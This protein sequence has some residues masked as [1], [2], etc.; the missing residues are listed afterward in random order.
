MIYDSGNNKVIFGGDLEILRSAADT[1]AL[2]AGDVWADNSINWS[3]V[4]KTGSSLADLATRAYSDLTGR[5]ADDDFNTLTAET[6]VEDTDIVLIYDS[7]ASAYRKM[8]RANFV[9]GVASVAAGDT[10]QIQFNTADA[11]NADSN[12]FWDNTNKWLGIGTSTPEYALEVSG[13]TA[14]FGLSC[15]NT[16]ATQ[17]TFYLRKARGTEAS[18]AAVQDADYLGG[19]SARVYT[20]AGSWQT[21]GNFYFIAEGTPATTN[22]PTSFYLALND[23]TARTTRLY[24]SPGGKFAT[25]GETAP[26][27]T[28]G[29]LCLNQGANDLNILTFKSSDISQPQ[30]S[31]AETDTYFKAAKLQATGGGVNLSGYTDTDS[32]FKCGMYLGGFVASAN[33]G[34]TEFG[35][36]TVD[37]YKTDGGAGSI[38]LAGTENSFAVRNGATGVVVVVKGT[39]DILSQA[40]L[41]IASYGQTAAAGAIQW[42][43]TNFQGYNGSSWVNLDTQSTDVA[44]GDTGQ[45]QFNTADAFN[46]DSNLFWDNTNKRLAVGNATPVGVIH[47]YSSSLTAAESQVYVERDVADAGAAQLVFYRARGSHAALQASDWIGGVTYQGRNATQ[48]TNSAAIFSSVDG[49]PSA[50]VVPGTLDFWTREISGT[51][52]S[53]FLISS[54]GRLS[55]GGETAPDVD[56]GGLCLNH[57]AND[58]KVLS[59]KNGDVAHPFTSYAEADTYFTAVKA[60]NTGGGVSMDAYT[61]A[62]GGAAFNVGGYSATPNTGATGIGVVNVNFRKTDGSTGIA[63]I[64]DTDVGV[65]FRNHSTVKAVIFGSGD[66]VTQAGLKIASYGQTAAAGAIQW[67]GTNFQ[68]YNGTAWVNLDESGASL[69]AGSDTQI[70]FNNAG[71]FG[72][73]SNLTWS[74][75]ALGVGGDVKVG[76]TN[77]YYLG[78][79]STDGSWRFGLDTGDMVLEKRVSGVWEVEHKFKG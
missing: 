39:G 13:T 69:V 9:S 65:S 6:G 26:D 10:G 58:G 16:A 54:S 40:G 60:S 49:T 53:R 33:S 25:G 77:Y 1:I 28:A 29:G 46:A 75:T 76:S 73:S 32:T 37:S 44:A 63:A 64:A 15:Y 24:I 55:T 47:T 68:G 67:S 50:T 74:G 66:F 45:I 11:F 23:G 14:N 19:L 61:N 31:Q 56:P 79:P 72:A 30:L 20:P 17:S 70:Q 52:A 34:A 35:A 62:T 51:W 4:S 2:G 3:G 22:V 18:P 21:S 27:V 78:D 71:A 7:S 41:K 57:G 59:F 12:L 8:T 48:Y 5:P 36:V 38:A 43:G 42:S